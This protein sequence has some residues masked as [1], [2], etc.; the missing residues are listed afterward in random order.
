MNIKAS[1]GSNVTEVKFSD[2]VT[3]D[4]NVDKTH[5]ASVKKDGYY[6]QS[7]DKIH[8]TVTVTSSGPS[9]DVV[10][11]DTV[12]GTALTYDR[13]VTY[14]STKGAT[15]TAQTKD[16]GFTAEIPSMS[17]GEEVKFTYTATVDYDKLGE[18]GTVEQQET[19]N[20]VKIT[21]PEDSKPEDNS[22]TQYVN[23]ISFSSIGKNAQSVSDEY[24]ESGKTYRDITWNI[25]ANEERKKHLTYIADSI[26]ADSQNVISYSG[27]G[28]TIVVTHENGLQEIRKVMWTDSSIEKTNTGWKYTPPASDGKASY[29][30]TYTTKA[31][32]TNLIDS[33]NVSNG[34]NT[35]YNSTTGNVSVG[36]S[37]ENQFNASKSVAIYT[38]NE[39][40]WEITVNVPASGLDKLVVTDTLPS[41]WDGDKQQTDIDS[42]GEILSV[43]GLDGAEAYAVD[44][45]SDPSKFTM[46]FYKDKAKTKPGMNQSAGN[47]MVTIRYTTKNNRDW[48]DYSMRNPYWNYLRKR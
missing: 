24:K 23:Y 37:G 44:S 35:N 30:V 40:K 26:A 28:L 7:D 39:I 25:K 9:K 16:N 34:A 46:T 15:A 1:F 43:D 48:L 18:S 2:T 27:E 32:V 36:P 17:D 5:N 3:R 42:F 41:I 11:T 4:V 6:D 20:G 45:T 31:D 8:Y 22:V 33:R 10:V 21:C 29:D 13:N 38:E 12:N 47:R 14:T 19:S